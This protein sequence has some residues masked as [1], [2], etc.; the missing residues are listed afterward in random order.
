MADGFGPSVAE[1]TVGYEDA[2]TDPR[3][4]SDRS[5]EPAPVWPESQ[6]LR[7]LVERGPAR[8]TPDERKL[9]ATSLGRQVKTLGLYREMDSLLAARHRP[10]KE[11]TLFAML[12]PGEGRDNTGIKDLNDKVLGY[13]YTNTFILARQEEIGKLFPPPE[14][15]PAGPRFMTLGQDYKTATV[16][17]AQKTQDQAPL[18]FAKELVT[19]DARLR[20]RLLDVLA[21]A[22]KD[23]ENKSR[24]PEIDKLTRVL[25]KNP[26][27]RFDFLFGCGHLVIDGHVMT[28]AFRLLTET[29]K[30]AG[31]ARFAAKTPGLVRHIRQYAEGRGVDDPVKG[32]DAR[33]RRFD[34][35][36][37]LKVTGAAADLKN[38]ALTL[39]ARDLVRDLQ[40][41]Y[42]DTVWTVAFLIHKRLYWANPDVIRDVRKGLLKPPELGDGTKR[43]F[44]AQVDLLELWLVTV[45]I[46]DIIKDF[47]IGEF[48]GVLW[49]YHIDAS[50]ALR[51]VRNSQD[52]V[53]WSLLGRLLTR[54]LR[55]TQEPVIVH[56]NAS[57]YQFFAYASDHLDQIFFSMD[58]RDLGVE[59]T[60]HYEVATKEIIDKQLGE[61]DLLAQT[62]ASTDP[63]VERRR[64]VHDAVVAVF[65]KYHG[66]LQHGAGLV[67]AADRAFGGPV[68]RTL[69]PDFRTSVRVML[70]GDEVF[71]SAHPYYALYEHEIIRD[72]AQPRLGD[73][74]LNMR[75]GVAYSSA[76]R[77]MSHSRPRTSDPQRRENQL[78]HDR[79]LTL[80]TNATGVLK[81]LE[82]A[83]RRIE[84]LIDKLEANHKKAV[85]GQ[86]Y[87]PRLA[88][89][90]LLRLYARVRTA[91]ADILPDT[92]Y[93]RLR[94][95]LHQE[96]LI[97][98][99]ETRSVELVDHS[100]GAI[101]DGAQLMSEVEKLEKEVRKEVGADNFHIDAVLPTR[102][103][104]WMEK[105][106]DVGLELRE[107]WMKPPAA[108]TR[109]PPAA[110]PVTAFVPPT[111]PHA[112]V[113]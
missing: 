44:Q 22:A 26:K 63:I 103:P 95:L 2:R 38:A 43:S 5:R 21:L 83:H 27:Y 66:K 79:A 65:R 71:V 14:K 82:R 55:Q 6:V 59:L 29:L 15:A 78:A 100:T 37:Y 42:V 33:G 23:P 69:P 93:R 74:A 105:A 41:V 12:F 61:R 91:Y 17:A 40:T 98:S 53:D 101:V 16:I 3:Y 28:V 67:A 46:I 56:G 72:L 50:D 81:P 60:T 32:H 94:R 13:T 64:T 57:E 47:T 49:R 20:Q 36:V 7:E 18:D 102:I 62:L 24:L 97:K 9:L 25:T 112:R 85:R 54:D 73:R 19:L 107:E 80:S 89:L 108:P 113:R 87:R 48:T 109:P 96:D 35:G 8:P 76:K 104:K 68:A 90:R 106:V 58:I 51:Q 11:A 84:R 45:N 110:P 34:T 4:T 10:P 86:Y 92:A 52:E 70:G 31:M 99:L 75:T 1:T 77:T 39:N 88:N 111:S 30:A